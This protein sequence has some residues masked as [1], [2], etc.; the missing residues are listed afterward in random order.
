MEDRRSELRMKANKQVQLI[1]VE[2]GV[3]RLGTLLDL[4]LVGA[5]VH[6]P[7]KIE[8]GQKIDLIFDD[9]QQRLRSTVIWNT[10]TEIG[11]SFDAPV[12]EASKD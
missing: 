11:I 12:S 8:A 9:Q 3:V 1:L 10:E 7:L 4:S 5:R 6:V 2:G